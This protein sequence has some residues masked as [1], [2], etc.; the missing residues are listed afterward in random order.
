MT[1]R[2]TNTAEAAVERQ[3]TIAL[4]DDRASAMV[5]DVR[6]GLA[7]AGPW[8]ARGMVLLDTGPQAA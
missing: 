3:V 1:R 8:Q 4:A 2:S 6:E 7:R 5:A